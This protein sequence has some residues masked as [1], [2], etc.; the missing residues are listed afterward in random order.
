MQ[1]HNPVLSRNEGFATNGRYAT[2]DSAATQTAQ[3]EQM[4]AAPPT[5]PA[6]RR[7]TLDDVVMRTGMMF[8]LL[9]AGAVV[10][11]QLPG[12]TF[13]AMFVGLGLG[14]WAALKREPVPALFLAYAA[15]EGVFVG[16]ISQWYNL[17]SF[18]Q[19]NPYLVQQA[20][21]ATFAVFVVSLV[22]YKVRAI[23]VTPK[24]TRMVII[25]T[26]GYA[27]FALLNF[28]LAMFGVGDGWGIRGNGTFAILVG[29]FAVGLAALNLVLDFDFIEQ[30]VANGLPE[31][32]AWTAA[33]G[34]VV[35]LVWLYLEMLRL[36]ALLTGRE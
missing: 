5:V 25:A 26:I 3:L 15:V 35:T 4:W 23:R 21:L 18:G 30:G 34:L 31:K 6:V 16:G 9:L 8:V 24:F 28:V 2:F 32:Y 14:I 22:A 29:L 13:P 33:F 10:G 12:L 11:W 1:S 17:S 7:M 19:N 27:V 20:V 36:I